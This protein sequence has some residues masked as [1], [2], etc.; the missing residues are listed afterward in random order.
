MN[1]KLSNLI[2]DTREDEEDVKLIRYVPGE[3]SESRLVRSLRPIVKWFGILSTIIWVAAALSPDTFH[4]PAD[5][6]GWVFLVS[7]IWF[8]AFC[9]GIFTL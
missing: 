5:S 2:S 9:A 8:F 7:I 6:Q 3:K 1:T 4:V